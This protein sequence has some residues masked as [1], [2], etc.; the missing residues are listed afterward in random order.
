VSFHYMGRGNGKS[1][2]IEGGGM[3]IEKIALKNVLSFRDS[4]I[5]LG[6]LN[7]L[8][9]PNAAG[10][11]NLFS[12]ISLLQSAPSTILD[13]IIQ[14]GGPAQWIWLGDGNV[15]RQAS[16][17]CDLRLPVRGDALSYHL[18][19]GEDARGFLI[20]R[21]GLNRRSDGTNGSHLVFQ[22]TLQEVSLG[23]ATNAGGATTEVPRSES[24]LALFRLPSDPTPITE[25]ARR[26][27]AIRIY[28]EFNTGPL[29]PIR[30]GAPTAVL[31]DYLSPTGDNLAMLL[32][33]WD[34]EGTLAGLRRYITRLNDRFGDP[35][36]RISGNSAQLTLRENG[37]SEPMVAAR[38]SDGTL[39]F[40][41]ILAALLTPTPPSLICIEEP[42]LGLH[43]DALSLV[44]E[45]LREAS[46]KT[47]V[48][49]TTHSQALVDEFSGSPESVLVCERDFDGGTQMKRLSSEQLQE[50]LEDYSL[51]ELWRKGEIGGNRW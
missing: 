39:R 12:A 8:I 10:K 3:L 1:A 16:I 51:G 49:V 43:P 29:S 42:E 32:H 47:Q 34:V 28:R 31:T 14:G 24:F 27:E 7:I 50:W 18:Q 35:K 37:L 44:A 11:S 33:N 36:A 9:G 40:L 4:C 23:I 25:V 20:T 19:F 41:C 15:A 48:I 13:A 26:F 2:K 17:S 22:R 46:E 5:E 45:A 21:E 6:R 30:T 38:L